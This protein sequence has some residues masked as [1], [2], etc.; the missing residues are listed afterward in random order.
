ML[1]EILEI[2]EKLMIIGFAIFLV[3][4]IMLKFNASLDFMKGSFI[5]EGNIEFL[6]YLTILGFLV[7]YVMKKLLLWEV[8][9]AFGKP[10]RRRN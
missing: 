6:I 4:I 7:S 9:L 1:R 3:F 5:S 10:K 8:H 2:T